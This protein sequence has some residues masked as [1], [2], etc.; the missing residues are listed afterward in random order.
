MTLGGEPSTPLERAQHIAHLMGGNG[1]TTDQ[2]VALVAEKLAKWSRTDAFEAAGIA[3]PSDGKTAREVIEPMVWYRADGWEHGGH[4]VTW[5]DYAE[6]LD[7][8]W[9]EQQQW[10]S[11]IASI[12][13]PA[14][15]S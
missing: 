3:T 4:A 1:L 10:D 15:V 6:E 14:E 8:L 9:Q 2:Q 7:A 12:P 5:R 13:P 11:L